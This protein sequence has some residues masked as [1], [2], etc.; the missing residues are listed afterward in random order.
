MSLRAAADSQ[1]GPDGNVGNPVLAVPAMPARSRARRKRA[2]LWAGGVGLAIVILVVSLV[3]L[4]RQGIDLGLWLAEIW[5]LIA[6]VPVPFVVLACCLKF[7]EVALNA[8]A[9]TVVLRAA[10][11]N[12]IIHFRQTLGVVQGGV[13]IFSIIPPKFGGLIL[14]ALYRAGFPT[15][16]IPTVL[17]TRVVQGI[18]SSILGAV[19]LLAFG[20]ASAGFGEQ[21]GLV[22]DVTAFV[23][24][25]PLLTA[26]LILLLVGLIIALVR[27]SREMVRDL[28]S[29]MLLGGAILRTPRRYVF[30]VVVPTLLAFVL[31]WCVTGTLLAAFAIPVTLETLLRVNV[32]H[33]IA[34]S[35]QLV[36]GGFGTTQA[37]DL[38]ALNG[39][40]PVEVITAYSLTQG[41]IL[42]LFNLV[43]GLI[44]LVWSIGW[45]RTVRLL[46]FPARE[47]KAGSPPVAPQVTAG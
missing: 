25:Q 47:A 16:N 4:Q 8:S 13:A 40:A 11:P 19:V 22:A 30:L 26:T 45:E 21:G 18:S 17:A 37:F 28:T 12:E 15:L 31:R 27:H 20:A 33:G 23:E 44:A 5:V 38:V 46:R 29:Q 7:A 41:A 3:F 36:P 14:L 35:V 6:A 34:R 43:F 42:L 24:E 9:W 32:S 39:F 2:M 10:Y 1:R